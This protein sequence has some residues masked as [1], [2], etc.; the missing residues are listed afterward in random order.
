MPILEEKK[1]I[2]LMTSASIL[3][4]YEKLHSCKKGWDLAIYS[5]VDGCREY[6]AK[7]NKSDWERQ[8]LHDFTP[9]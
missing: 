2:K 3:G 8:I 5:N 6:Y 7:W 4:N 1:G 9:M